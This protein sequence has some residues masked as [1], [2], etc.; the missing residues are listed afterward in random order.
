MVSRWLRQAELSSIESIV[1]FAFTGKAYSLCN[2]LPLYFA[3][4][5]LRLEEAT[6]ASTEAYPLQ[7]PRGRIDRRLLTAVPDLPR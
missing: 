3:Q 4:N 5:L 6:Q 7:L 1:A 2:R